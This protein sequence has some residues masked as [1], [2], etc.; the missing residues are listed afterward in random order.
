[1]LKYLRVVSHTCHTDAFLSILNVSSRSTCDK[2]IEKMT[3]GVEMAGLPLC[4]FIHDII[5]TARQ[6]D[7]NSCLVVAIRYLMTST[8]CASQIQGHGES[9]AEVEAENGVISQQTWNWSSHPKAVT[10]IKHL[11]NLRRLSLR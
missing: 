3:D 1:M 6:R 10:K 11:A 9:Y 7:R 4:I 8:T 2:T 5:R